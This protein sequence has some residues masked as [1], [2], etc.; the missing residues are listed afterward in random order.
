MAERFVKGPFERA[1]DYLFPALCIVC[2]SPRQPSDRFLCEKCVS[3]LA[4]NHS[5]RQPCP[6]CA[7]NR[8]LGHCACTH[9]GDR[10]WDHPFESAY[11]ILDFDETVK[12]VMH[13]MKYRAKKRFARY[14]GAR[15]AGM[16]PSEL[17]AS[18]DAMV[19][20]PLHPARRKKR[21]YNQS[22]LFARG[23]SLSRPGLPVLEGVLVRVRDTRSQTKLDREQRLKNMKGAFA[24][25]RGEVESIRG[26]HLLLVDDVITTGATTTAAA[27]ALLDAGCA[28][29]RVLSMARD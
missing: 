12:A 5:R 4:V 27:Q 13:Q 17:F 16:V 18:V 14:C 7:M 29:V 6:R 8:S 24:V 21:G 2:D 26:K 25:T 22:L 9:G 15:L 28:S 11:A 19:A 23:I 3:L 10:G 1:I 20:V